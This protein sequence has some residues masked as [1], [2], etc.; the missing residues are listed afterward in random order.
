METC[1]TES[2]AMGRRERKIRSQVG[3]RQ[4]EGFAVASGKVEDPNFL[5]PQAITSESDAPPIG[6]ERRIA[7]AQSPRIQQLLW[8]CWSAA[9]GYQRQT[10]QV[11]GFLPLC[12]N[13]FVAVAAHRQVAQDS[14]HQTHTMRRAQDSAAGHVEVH[15]LDSGSTQSFL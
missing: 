9:S 5:I 8:T 3:L 14:S 1:N 7:V 13:E 10:S 12:H 15:R 11:E 6:G 2:P 4:S